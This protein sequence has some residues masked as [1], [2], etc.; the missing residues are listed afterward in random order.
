MNCPRWLIIGCVAASG[1]YTL[2]PMRFVGNGA[3]ESIATGHSSHPVPGQAD[4]P[5]CLALVDRAG[6]AVVNVSMHTRQPGFSDIAQRHFDIY[7]ALTGD[8]AGPG[9]YAGI[10]SGDGPLVR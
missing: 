10:P 6:P 7:R 4:R 2:A 8:R 1:L 5:D 9:A 3:P